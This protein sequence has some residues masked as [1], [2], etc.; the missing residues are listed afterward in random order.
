MCPLNIWQV[1]LSLAWKW[2]FIDGW[3]SRRF[4]SLLYY[5]LFRPG[6]WVLTSAAEWWVGSFPLR[7]SGSRQRIYNGWRR[8]CT[9]RLA[10]RLWEGRRR[11]PLGRADEG[12]PEEAGQGMRE[13][14]VGAE[15]LDRPVEGVVRSGRRHSRHLQLLDLRFL[16]PLRF[17][18]PVLEPDLHLQ[19]TK[20]VNVSFHVSGRHTWTKLI[21]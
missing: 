18:P 13:E 1:A 15:V 10:T 5:C 2:R 19:G 8:L 3:I 4:S 6:S 9:E 11:R 7:T 16:Q 21:K 20:K 12:V 17:R 14:L